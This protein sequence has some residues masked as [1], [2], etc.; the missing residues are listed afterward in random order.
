[1]EQFFPL[2]VTQYLYGGLLVGFGISLIYILVGL[3]AGASSVFTSTWSYFISN[4]ASF[5]RRER[6]LG[7]R[8]WRISLALGLVLGG[9]AY[10]FF[11]NGGDATVTELSP[12]RLFIGGVI[13]GIGTRMA[14]GCTSGHGICGNAFGSAPSFVSTITFLTVGIVTALI[15]QSFLG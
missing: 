11:V 14:G 15:T 8:H 7:T 12:W 10:L 4:P 6:F 13:V 2:G 9:I 1:M 5:F 3:I